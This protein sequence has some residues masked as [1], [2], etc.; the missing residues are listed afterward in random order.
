MLEIV[1][2][3]PDTKIKGPN[4]LVGKGIYEQGHVVVEWWCPAQQ[5]R[6]SNL[7]KGLM[8]ELGLN[9]ISKSS[10]D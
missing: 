2:G 3:T 8:F 5:A 6:R 4:H 9:V 7:R 10:S 1:L